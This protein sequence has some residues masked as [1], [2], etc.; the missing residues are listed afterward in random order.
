MQNI[1]NAFNCLQSVGN[2]G[3]GQ[4]RIDFQDIVGAIIFPRGVKYS[5]A[6]IATEGAF[7]AAL[8][9]SSYDVKAKRAFPISGFGE[10]TDSSE[11]TKTET[12]AYG[13]PLVVREGFMNWIFR[14]PQDYCLS[15]RL[16]KFNQA[17]VDVMFV[18]SAGTLIGLQTTQT[19][20][21][22]TTVYFGGIP[23]QYI[24]NKVFKVNDGNKLTQYMQQFVWD[25]ALA[26]SISFVKLNAGDF[27]SV[28][29]LLD[30]V[31]NTPTRTTNTATLTGQT[32]C[33]GAYDLGTTYG[34]Q[35]A[36]STLWTWTDSVTGLP[37]AVSSV[38]Y[39]ASTNAYTVTALSSDPN[40]VAG[41]KA[42]ISLAAASVLA[43][44]GLYL[45][46]NSV[47]TPS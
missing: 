7:V 22:T 17:N 44:Q 39:N 35:L 21:G 18:D 24:W 6:A 1:I 20:A 5:A 28:Q 41:N 10:I 33:Y 3:V 11:D 38:A 12:L 34:A 19:V 37:V 26:N 43:A 47:I 14:L 46:S 13:A 25:Q 36:V 4:C 31:L 9:A 23:Q 42:Y 45:E 30:V 2:T 15:N 32:L 29:G 40:Y 27:A 16:R 8:Q